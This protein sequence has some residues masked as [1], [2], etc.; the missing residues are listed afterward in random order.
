MLQ[1]QPHQLQP[2][3]LVVPLTLGDDRIPLLAQAAD[4]AHVALHLGTQFREPLPTPTVPCFQALSF[5]RRL[6]QGRPGASSRGSGPYFSQLLGPPPLHVPQPRLG[7]P[8]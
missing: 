7:A 3:P 6:S 2:E 8:Q 1:P 4:V 5:S